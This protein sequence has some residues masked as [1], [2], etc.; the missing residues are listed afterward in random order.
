MVDDNSKSP[1]YEVTLPEKDCKQISFLQCKKFVASLLIVCGAR[2]FK[3]KLLFLT[4]N[5]EV[6]PA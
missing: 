2:E 1:V 3:A 5:I 6:R 4:T